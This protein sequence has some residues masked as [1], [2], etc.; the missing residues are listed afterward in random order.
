LLHRFFP[1]LFLE[2]PLELL[3][4]NLYWVGIGWARR[5]I[6]HSPAEPPFTPT[7]S[8]ELGRVRVPYLGRA[9]L[10]WGSRLCPWIRPRPRHRWDSPAT[11]SPLSLCH[12]QADP[13]NQWVPLSAT[14]PLSPYF[15]FWQI[16]CYY[17]KI[18]NLC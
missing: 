11:S 6:A 9:A 5:H 2:I 17:W 16:Q 10:V 18:H 12:C 1:F 14:N 13:A 15:C 8:L 3:G 7:S 4:V